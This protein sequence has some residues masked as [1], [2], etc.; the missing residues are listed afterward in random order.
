MSLTKRLWRKYRGRWIASIITRKFFVKSEFVWTGFHFHGNILSCTMCSP[1]R[2]LVPQMG[3][4]R[5]LQSQNISRPSN[6]PI[7]IHVMSLQGHTARREHKVT[8]T[9]TKVESSSDRG[10]GNSE[11]TQSER[12]YLWVQWFKGSVV[13]WFKSSDEVSTTK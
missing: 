13:Q 11:A 3:S 8:V 5:Q 7:A 1:S 2:N 12:K 10:Q 6:D 4:A 9:V